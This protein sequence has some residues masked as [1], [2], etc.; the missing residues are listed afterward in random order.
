MLTSSHL[1]KC[2]A[3]A[4]A[5]MGSSAPAV[6]GNGP[7]IPLQTTIIASEGYTYG[8]PIMLMDATRNAATEVPYVC[9]LGGPVNTITH[10]LEK[11]TADFR[12]VVRPNVDTLYSSAFLDLSEGPM[13]L[14]VPAVQDRFYLLALLDAW[15]NNFAGTGTQTNRGEARTYLITGPGWSGA[16]PPDAEQISAPTNLVWII[17]RTELKNDADISAANAV[18]KAIKLFPLSGPVPVRSKEPCQPAADKMPPEDIVR[19]M[20]GVDFFA[21]LDT[22]IKAYPPATDDSEKLKKLGKINVGPFANGSVADLSAANKD[23]LS[24]GMARGQKSMDFAFALGSHGDWL[25][26]PTKI[27]L[28]NY[29]KD[30]LVRGIV[31]QIGFGANRNDFA[32]YQNAVKTRTGKPLDGAKGVYRL[33]FKKGELPPVKAFWSVTVYNEE[34]FLI[35]NAPNRS[36]LGSNSNL[37]AN[38]DGDIVITFAVRKPEDVPAS[39]W[40]PTPDGPFEVTLRMYWPEKAILEGDW[41]TPSIELS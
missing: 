22:L 33:T 16:L 41:K 19:N 32:V 26:N 40:L 2:A 8:F 29:D 27:P 14:E 13:V 31:S 28:G 11:P 39:N 35:E 25:P 5:L 17:G 24:V 34:G 21:R 15:T 37:V 30:Y 9:G 6:A 38:K 12:A 20:N 18:Q 10:M 4:A 1:L 36:A 7:S 23:A 3:L